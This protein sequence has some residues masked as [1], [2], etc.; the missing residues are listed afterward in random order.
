[1]GRT[2]ERRKI[3]EHI[4]ATREQRPLTKATPWKAIVSRIYLLSLKQLACS[5]EAGHFSETMPKQPYQ[6][7]KDVFIYYQICMQMKCLEH[8]SKQQFLPMT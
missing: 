7:V 1:M 2:E 3:Q 6:N 4:S 8:S 5:L